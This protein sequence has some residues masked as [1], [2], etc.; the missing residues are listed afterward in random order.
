MDRDALQAWLD[1]PLPDAHAAFAA[2]DPSIERLAGQGL[3]EDALDFAA[4]LLGLPSP[5]GLVVGLEEGQVS[6]EEAGVWSTD[7]ES[8][9][10]GV[11]AEG[12]KR[13]V[14]LYGRSAGIQWLRSTFRVADSHPMSG[15]GGSRSTLRVYD[16]DAGMAVSIAVDYPM[17]GFAVAGPARASRLRALATEHFAHV[18]RTFS[19]Q[20]WRGREGPEAVRDWARATLAELDRADAA[21]D[22]RTFSGPLRFELEAKGLFVEY[23]AFGGT[24]A[25]RVMLR[26]TGPEQVLEGIGRSF[27]ALFTDPRP[28]DAAWLAEQ[29]RSLR[30][31]L[32]AGDATTSQRADHV[33]TVDPDNLWARITKALSL[34]RPEGLDG[35]PDGFEVRLTRGVLARLKHQNLEAAAL[36]ERALAL[37]PG[38][39]YA[40]AHAALALLAAKRR[41]PDIDPERIVGHLQAALAAEPDPLRFDTRPGR[42]P[43]DLALGLA[44]HLERLVGAE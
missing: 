1:A 11:V 24:V 44:S 32:A 30:E 39:H 8:P 15:E 20:D 9:I 26:V 42:S 28:R 3:R 5:A 43:R 17:V 7:T 38:D 29:V 21:L 12:T 40:H 22:L 36:C 4:A 31:G 13:T 10:R 16:L 18:T 25:P 34:I 33:L 41:H 35:L 19:A 23:R 6:R 14:P 2:L 27:A 37:R